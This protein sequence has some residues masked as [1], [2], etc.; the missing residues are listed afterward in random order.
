MALVLVLVPG[1]RF[2]MGAQHEDP[3]A[4]NFHAQAEDSESPVHAVNLEP[5]FIAKYECT[6]A[7]WVALTCGERPSGIQP[8]P[9]VSAILTEYGLPSDR[10]SLLNPVESEGWSRSVEVLRSYGLRLPSEAEWE[11]ARR[12]GG[13]ATQDRENPGADLDEYA[14]FAAGEDNLH[15]PVGQKYPNA[16]GLYDMQ[17]NVGEWCADAWRETY[18]GAALDGSPVGGE[19][20]GLHVVRGGTVLTP[21]DWLRATRRYASSSGGLFRMFLG[22]R[23]AR[24]LSRQ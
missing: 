15:H 1:G 14:W 6:Q 8:G 19:V 24:D 21:Q 3:A 11:Y 12:A 23:P 4:P 20:A 22:V 18:Q 9:K 10:V 17:G 13:A 2:L 16:F 5:Y 7:Q